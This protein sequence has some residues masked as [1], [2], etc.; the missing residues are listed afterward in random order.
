MLSFVVKYELLHPALV[1]GA[2]LLLIVSLSLSDTYEECLFFLKKR[3]YNSHFLP[4]T[5]YVSSCHNGIII[6]LLVDTTCLIS[7]YL[8]KASDSLTGIH[9]GSTTRKAGT[10]LMSFS[11]SQLSD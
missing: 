11:T 7:G 6:Y 4:I 9:S 10:V 8:M 2:R 1:D 5:V 3:K